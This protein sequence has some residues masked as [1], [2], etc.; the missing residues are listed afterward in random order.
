MYTELYIA[1]EIRK[2]ISNIELE[3][4]NYMFAN[5]EKPVELPA[6]AFFACERWDRI[7][8]HAS[9][10]FIPKAISKFWSDVNGD[11]YFLVSLSN[12]KN[13]DG[14]INKFIDWIRPLLA[15]EVKHI[16]HYRYEEAVNPT[17]LYVNKEVKV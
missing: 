11:C 16:G 13:Y 1:A 2:D 12:L 10:Y 3:I 14:E 17:I 15:S 5:G 6:H 7:G 4:L 8:Q 9:Y